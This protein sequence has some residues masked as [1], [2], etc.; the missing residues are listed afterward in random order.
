[1][2]ASESTHV[3]TSIPGNVE[4]LLKQYPELRMNRESHKVLKRNGMFIYVNDTTCA[5]PSV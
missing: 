5:E 1:M 2:A 4:L 3:E